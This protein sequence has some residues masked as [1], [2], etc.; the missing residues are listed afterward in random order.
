MNVVA[1]CP[2]KRMLAEFALPTEILAQFVHNVCA[3][4]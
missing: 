1:M 2:E 3:H 4:A